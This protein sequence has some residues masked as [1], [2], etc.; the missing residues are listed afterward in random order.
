MLTRQL[1]SGKKVQTTTNIT[2]GVEKSKKAH[3]QD[4]IPVPHCFTL[5]DHGA[6]S[7]SEIRLLT[8]GS[9]L[10][11]ISSDDLAILR[12]KQIQLRKTRQS[13][14][15]EVASF[16]AAVR[17]AIATVLSSTLIF[18][19][20]EAGTAVCVDEQ[21]SILT[22]AHCFG[23]SQSEWRRQKKKWMLFYT[24]HAVLVECRKWDNQ[25]DLAL[26]RIIA[27]ELDEETPSTSIS[28][29]SVFSFV[30]VSHDEPNVATPIACVGQPGRDDLEATS[31]GRKTTYNLVEISSGRY[32]GLVP[33]VDP[34]DCSNIGSLK[35]DAWTYWGHSGAPLIRLSDGRLIGVHSSW[36]DQTAMRHGVPSVAIRG[37]LQET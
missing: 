6:E 3:L 13:I 1:R 36:D 24:G 17:G 2:A 5:A 34:Q 15:A 33:D 31:P 11:H 14:E 19:Q 16:P 4:P 7:S 23:E 28:V 10:P 37:F 32:R 12:A 20:H 30:K 27:L 18:A 29:Q 21:G 8:K 9:T 22:C 35:H 25:R 26:G